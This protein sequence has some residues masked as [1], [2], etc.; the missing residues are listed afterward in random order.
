[1]IQ[2]ELFYEYITGDRLIQRFHYYTINPAGEKIII[3]IED[4]SE[5]LEKER[6]LKWFHNGIEEMKCS[7]CQQNMEHIVTPD[8][9][10]YMCYDCPTYHEIWTNHFDI[11]KEDEK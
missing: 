8:W 7:E 5:H 1:M 11:E 6:E 4:I 3:K 9:N 2:R 10:Y